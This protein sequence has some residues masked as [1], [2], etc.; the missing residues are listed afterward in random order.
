MTIAFFKYLTLSEYTLRQA[1]FTVIIGFSEVLKGVILVKLTNHLAIKVLR[2]A[3]ERIPSA[4]ILKIVSEEG[5]RIQINIERDGNPEDKKTSMF[6]FTVYVMDQAT[7]LYISQVIKKERDSSDYLVLIAPYFSNASAKVCQESQ[8]GYCDLS[9]NCL[10]AF[11]TIFLSVIGN[12]N[13]Y[14]KQDRAKNIFKPSSRT[15][16]RILRELLKDV[17]VSWKLK[18]LAVKIGCSIGMISRVKTWL[19]EQ[20]WAVMDEE[21]LK[22]IDAEALMKAWA[23]VWTV[24]P[25]QVLHC[26]TLDP[27]PVFEEKCR[28]A[29]SKN[30]LETYLTGFSGGVRYAPVVRYNR[31]HLWIRQQDISRFLQ[32][33]GCKQVDSGS[34]VTLFVAEGEEIFSDSRVIQGQSI[35][36]PVQVYLDCMQLKGRGEELAEA[37]FSKEINK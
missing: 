22:I 30:G 17:S 35:A 9:G 10:I 21:G 19:C 14:P 28:Q 18:H 11:G 33:T 1:C 24:E 32:L 2:D 29:F 15:S 37:V 23:E 7:P 31:A 4:G 26:Y 6:P 16:S 20:Q 34:N 25:D 8:V 36:S 13:K 12:P 3:F 27:V 5:N